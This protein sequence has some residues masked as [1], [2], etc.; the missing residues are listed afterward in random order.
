MKAVEQT[1]KPLKD[2]EK[3]RS[4]EIVVD[5]CLQKD[6]DTKAEPWKSITPELVD[7]KTLKFYQFGFQSTNQEGFLY[8]KLEA[9]L[10]FGN[11]P[12]CG[13]RSRRSTD[14]ETAV[15]FGLYILVE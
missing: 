6:I 8:F 13:T 2:S 11:W 10:V 4:L 15:T 3:F 5:G 9:R 14:N 12:D 7:G 1:L